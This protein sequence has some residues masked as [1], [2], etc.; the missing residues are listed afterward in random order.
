[1]VIAQLFFGYTLTRSLD[2]RIRLRRDTESNPRSTGRRSRSRR[3]IT[4]RLHWSYHQPACPD[5]FGW[6]RCRD[7][8]HAAYRG[9]SS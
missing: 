3:T 7:R 8:G 6:P 9:T 4:Q 1:M 2:Q 5:Q